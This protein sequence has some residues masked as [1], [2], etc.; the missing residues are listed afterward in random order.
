[1]QELAGKN[2][3]IKLQFTVESRKPFPSDWLSQNDSRFPERRKCVGSHR[4]PLDA[5]GKTNT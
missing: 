5:I 1:M 2:F 4:V 3:S